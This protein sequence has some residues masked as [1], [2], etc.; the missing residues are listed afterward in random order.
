[1]DGWVDGWVGG[2]VDGWVDGTV[3]GWVGGWMDGWVDGWMDGWSLARSP[4]HSLKLHQL[5]F[6]YP[7]RMD[8]EAHAL[9]RRS[10]KEFCPSR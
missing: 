9:G 4:A 2:W 10:R 7:V 5:S 3:D 6:I 8:Y 1:M